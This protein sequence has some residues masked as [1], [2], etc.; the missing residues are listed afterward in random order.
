MKANPLI[1]A[2]D[3]CGAKVHTQTQQGF[4][5]KD[6][7]SM[8]LASLNS[9]VLLAIPYYSMTLSSML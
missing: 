9:V 6:I 8:N 1:S 3:A 5:S 7:S 4:E 2:A